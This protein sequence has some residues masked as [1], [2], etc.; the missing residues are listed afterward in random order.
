MSRLITRPVYTRRVETRGPS[1]TSTFPLGRGPRVTGPR[2]TRRQ[3]SS[4][5]PTFGVVHENRTGAEGLERAAHDA[6]IADGHDL[7]PIGLKMRTGDATN[8]GLRDGP[9]VGAVRVVIIVRQPVRDEARQRVR[10]R[11]GRLE[12]NRED[13]VEV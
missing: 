1:L 3:H 5:R 9:D 6:R 10:D 4:H 12:P 7:E 2:A 8:V 11:R 13:P